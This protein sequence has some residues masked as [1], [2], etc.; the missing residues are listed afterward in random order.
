MTDLEIFLHIGYH[1]TATTYLQDV[2][3]N[4]IPGVTYLGRRWINSELRDFFEEYKFTHDLNFSPKT[5]RA[6]FDDILEHSIDHSLSLINADSKTEKILISHESLHSG[7]EWFGVEIISRAERLK[8]VFPSAK[9]IIG[10]R[11]QVDYIESNY[12][13]YIFLGGRLSLKYLLYESFAF[14]YGLFTKLQYDKVISLYMDLFGRDSV[15]VYLHEDL[16]NN[17]DMA[18][19][20][21]VSFID[22]DL[23]VDLSSKSINR[24][25]GAFSL[26]LLRIVN[27]LVAYDFN[28]QYQNRFL[29]NSNLREKYRFKFANLLKKIEALLLKDTRP[30]RRLISKSDIN[31]IN[32]YFKD[33]NKSLA[34]LLSRDIANLGY[35]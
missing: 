13:E 11:N 20:G 9:I 1:K 32:D 18:I 19:Q 31:Y 22:A 15:Y 34:D 8:S 30:K 27:N 25:L 24:G 4:Q 33:S 28:E 29:R 12:K 23:D 26:E 10:I 2:V 5:Y 3:F 16:K 14:R 35:Y 17:F 21:I 6:K 7:A